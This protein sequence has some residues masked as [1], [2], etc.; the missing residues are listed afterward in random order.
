MRTLRRILAPAAL[1]LLH[2]AAGLAAESSAGERAILGSELKETVRASLADAGLGSD[3]VVAPFRRFGVCAGPLAVSPR[4]PGDWQTVEVSCPA[5]RPWTVLVRTNTTGAAP[6]E[7]AP[8]EPPRQAAAVEVLAEPAP[9]EAVDPARV[10]VLATSLRSGTVIAPEHLALAP[11]PQQVSAGLFT[12]PRPIVGRRLLRA[13]G[14]GQAVRARHLEHDW[15]VE[16]GR[17]VL[18]VAEIGGLAVAMP[19]KAL[20]DGQIGDFVKVE[21]TSSGRVIEGI[22]EGPEKI[23]PIANIP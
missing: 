19:G 7:P 14:A 6:Q 20:G 23:R 5:P 1:L 12:D 10:V 15:A 2:A 17:P 8:Q 18:I 22:V 13:L 11:A 21:N 16:R 9:A 4:R 3:P